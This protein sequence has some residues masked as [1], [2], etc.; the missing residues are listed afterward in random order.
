MRLLIFNLKQEKKTVFK[1][2]KTTKENRENS[3]KIVLAKEKGNFS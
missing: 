3:S 2:I 1:D